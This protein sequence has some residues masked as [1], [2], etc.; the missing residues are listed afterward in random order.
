MSVRANLEAVAYY[1]SW[2]NIKATFRYGAPGMNRSGM[3]AG[4]AARARALRKKI[5]RLEVRA[6]KFHDLQDPENW[7]RVR[8][9]LAVARK[10]LD[11]YLASEAERKRHAQEEA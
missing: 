5:A 11:D 4:R 7:M 8:G 1:F 9:R 6:K 2:S 10:V 3:E